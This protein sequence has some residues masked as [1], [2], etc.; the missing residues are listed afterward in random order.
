MEV[1]S[2]IQLKQAGT[3]DAAALLDI[4]RRCFA[5]L[6][7]KYQDYDTNPAMEPL[8][9]I[10]RKI[11]ERDYYFILEDGKILGFACVRRWEEVCRVSP[12]GVLPEY[13]GRGVGHRAMRLLEERYPDIFCWELDT[14]LQEPGLCRFYE[15]LGYRRTGGSHEIKPGMDII[16]FCKR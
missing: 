11:S 14:I 15:S 12:I 13:Q 3:G 2:V 7:E 4:Q 10:R 1:K 5:A 9:S 6:L 8:E 16:D